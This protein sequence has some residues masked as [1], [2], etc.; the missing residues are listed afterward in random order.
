MRSRVGFLFSLAVMVLL[1]LAATLPAVRPAVAQ[2]VTSIQVTGNQRV[3]PET[4]RSYI[5]IQSGEAATPERIDE[6]IKSLFQ[7]G[8]FSDVQIY[9]QGAVLV[10]NVEENPLINIVSFEG[11]SEIDDDTLAKEVELR[12]R[13]IYTRARVQADVQ[14]ILAVYRRS[15]FFGARVEPK[16]IRLPQNR[17]NLVFEIDEGASTSI[18]SINFIGNEAFSD[19]TL[20]NVIT[21]GESAWWKFFSASDNYDPDRLNYDKELL[22]RYYLK[23]GFADFR[24]VSA[25]AELAPDGESFFITFTVEEG[26]QYSVGEVVIN[27]G[28][29]NIDPAQLQAAM[30]FGAGETFDASKVDRSVEQ[31]TVEAGRAGYA[32]AKV[33]PDIQRDEANQRLNITFNIEEGPRVYIER[34]DII[35]NT[36]TLDEVIRREIQLMEGDA[37]NRVIVD[38]ARRRLTALDFFAKIDFREQPGSAP[39]KVVL[40]IEVEEKS[41]GTINF[42]AGYSTIEG[43]IGSISVTER[44][45]LGRGQIVNLSTALS[46]TRQSLNFSFTE[47][48]FLDRNVSAGVDAF[49]TRSDETDQS[50]YVMNQVGGA[51]RVGFRLSEL[52]RVTNKYSLSWRDV[53]VDDFNSQYPPGDPRR[54]PDVAPAI[55]QAEGTDL[56]SMLSSTLTLDDLDNPLR[57]TNGYRFVLT[58][59][60]A[61]LGGDAYFGRVDAA[62]YYFM[63]LFFDGVVLKLKATSGYVE[64]WNGDQVDIL[65]RFTKGGDSF[66]GFARSGIGPRQER[67]GNGVDQPS[68]RTDAIGGQV[69]AIGTVE[70]TFPVGLPEE[71]GLEGS[72]FMD[73]GTVFMAPEDDIETTD[74]FCTG[75]VCEVFG[76]NAALRA[77]V[78][79]GLIWDSPFGP[80]RLNVSYPFLKEDYDQTEIVQFSVGTRF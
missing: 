47:P 1:A 15:G 14:R 57:P 69:Y 40:V 27:A 23:N 52:A 70:T 16:I 21:T 33:Q 66:R 68:G 29:T 19:W 75:G 25:T 7:T 43:I 22:R 5:P 26:P 56:I 73:V 55:C 31:M 18:A 30:T 28:Q 42:S 79:A 49:I 67:P 13:T 44:N 9:R 46:F 6:A 60:L 37:Y 20:R 53:Q 51:A 12:E 3:E 62:A 10:V 4:V 78:G 71:F 74:A 39:D 35:G 54:C 34:I 17:V 41:T 32:F 59:D 58:G 36:R 65:D 80:L 64:G 2:V 76:N 8:L 77:S 48:Y 72:L 11:N 38:R 50:S 63:P 45:F 61:G 24:V